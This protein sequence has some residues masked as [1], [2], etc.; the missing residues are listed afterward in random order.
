MATCAITGGAEKNLSGNVPLS[1]YN[2]RN[3]ICLVQHVQATIYQLL[4]AKVGNF[5]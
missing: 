1:L 4:Q 5:L 2:L 3:S